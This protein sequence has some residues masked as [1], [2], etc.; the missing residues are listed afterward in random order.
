MSA[1]PNDPHDYAP[2]DVDAVLPESGRLVQGSP[3]VTIEFDD[4]LPDEAVAAVREALRTTEGSE[5]DV[6]RAALSAGI[7][8]LAHAPR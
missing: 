6:A 1:M 8:A 7:R 4:D 3:N 2:E 5:D